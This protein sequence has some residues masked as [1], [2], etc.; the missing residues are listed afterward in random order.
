MTL[1]KFEPI[2]ELETLHDRIQRYFDDFPNFGFNLN[3]NFYPRIDISE[4]KENINV[5]AEI[6]GVNKN[7]IK[8][9]LQD[10]ILTIEGEKKKE[11]EQKEKNFFRS[12]RMYGS[13]KR[14]FTLPD[15]VDSDKVDAKFENGMLNIQLKKIEQKRRNEKVIELK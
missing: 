1:I 13:F 12:E 2:R 15:L 5:I 10:N 7:E 3:D 9:T 11:T 14:C 8:I 4:D 6:P